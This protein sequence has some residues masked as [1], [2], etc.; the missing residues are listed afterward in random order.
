MSTYA[1]GTIVQSTKVA[2]AKYEYAPRTT[3]DDR[4]WRAVDPLG[5]LVHLMGDEVG[6]IRF[7]D[8]DIL[9]GIH[10]GELEVI[11]TP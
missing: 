10:D 5:I 4:P 11:H 2:G 8:Q 7:D 9:L 1:E 3:N 6:E